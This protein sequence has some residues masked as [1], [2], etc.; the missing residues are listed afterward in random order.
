MKRAIT[1]IITSIVTL[2]VGAVAFIPINEWIWK[3]KGLE[4]GYDDEM[5]MFDILVFV[6]WPIFLIIGGLIGNALYKK[7]L[8]RRSS[9]R[10]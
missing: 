1:I 7:H 9:G 8:T 2:F 4:G 10:S 5:K 6:E 3:L